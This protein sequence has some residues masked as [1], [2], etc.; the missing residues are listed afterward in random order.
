MYWSAD[1]RWKTTNLSKKS[2]SLNNFDFSKLSVIIDLI[3]LLTKIL[4]FL[5]LIYKPIQLSK[6]QAVQLI[7][8]E[9]DCISVNS[10]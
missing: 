6:Y 2:Q 5:F 9:C 1:N 3:L 4:Q 7:S 8:L 10:S